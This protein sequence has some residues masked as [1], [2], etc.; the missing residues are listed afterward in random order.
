MSSPENVVHLSDARPETLTVD[1]EGFEGPLDLL[2]ALARTQKVD[3]ARISILAL[4]EQYLGFLERAR[5]LRLEIAADYLVMAAALAYLKSRL[6]LPEPPQDEA[7]SGEELAEQ[8]ALR[9]RKLE[10]I[11]E[12][13][14]QLQD[15]PQLGRDRFGRGMPEG[16]VTDRRSEWTAS[17]HDLLKAYAEQRRESTAS[18]V[19]VRIR[20]ALPLK[21]AREA[22]ERGLGRTRD[23]RQLDE[24]IEP[25]LGAAV[26][27][28]SAVASSFAAGLEL[29]R[30][31]RMQL[32]QECA[33]GPLYARRGPALAGGH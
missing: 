18:R 15:R 26:G 13:S 27:R 29:A 5:R 3:L 30:E 24:L 6:L 11:R 22:L 9:L 8:L 12:V 17:L 33:F 14:T 23:W 7:P 32:R 1:V 31:G 19:V 16:V 20:P 21:D 25:G 28:P 2:L 4:V 10:A